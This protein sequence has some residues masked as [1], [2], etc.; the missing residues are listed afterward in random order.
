M[1]YTCRHAFIVMSA[2]LTACSGA[3]SAPEELFIG[4]RFFKPFANNMAPLK[5]AAGQPSSTAQVVF[6][7]GASGSPQALWEDKKERNQIQGYL[8]GGN[9]ELFAMTYEPQYPTTEGYINW[10]DYALSHNTDTAFVLALPWPDYP[11]DYATSAEYAEVWYTG[12][13]GEWSNLLASLQELYPENQFINVPYGQSAVQLR[14]MF[15]AGLVPDVDALIG[16]QQD[17]SSQNDTGIFVDA[18]GHADSILVDLGT[19]V[20]GQFIYDI[21]PSEDL[22][23]SSYEVDL[24]GVAKSIAAEHLEP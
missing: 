4:H 15:E 10:I 24:I 1:V 19:L 18:K 2:L 13:E 7:G 6:S 11:E 14:E 21:E 12:V 5:A 16:N 20:W 23:P 9:V 8:D 17:A 22:L 3:S